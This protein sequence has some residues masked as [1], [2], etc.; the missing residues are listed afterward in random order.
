MCSPSLEHVSCIATCFARL[1]LSDLPAP[2][3]V[4]V[5]GQPCD[6]QGVAPGLLYCLTPASADPSAELECD[7][8]VTVQDQ[9][10]STYH[11]KV[12]CSQAT[13]HTLAPRK[14]CRSRP[15]LWV[16]KELHKDGYLVTP[17]EYAA[18]SVCYAGCFGGRFCVH[19]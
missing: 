7:V 3:R 16:W 6:K 13:A 2:C 14:C 15:A 1:L 12:H 4:E 9:T 18:A 19:P 8:T 11:F 10:V 17:W 5:C